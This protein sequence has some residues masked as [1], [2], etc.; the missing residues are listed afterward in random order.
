MR[1]LSLGADFV[2]LGRAFVYGVAALGKYG[3][4]HVTEVLVE[5]LK[6]NMI[7]LGVENIEELR[8]SKLI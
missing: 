6:N 5:D 7:Q 1:A 3:G 2:L 4:D 8:N